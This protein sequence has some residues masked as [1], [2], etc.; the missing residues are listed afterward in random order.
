MPCRLIAMGGAL[1][2][3]GVTGRARL[4]RPYDWQD[5]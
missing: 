2:L 5:S 3:A 4:G 1:L